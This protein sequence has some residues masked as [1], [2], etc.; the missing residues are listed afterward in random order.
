MSTRAPHTLPH[1]LEHEKAVLGAILRDH[2]A[3]V[4]NLVSDRLR[5]DHFF[6]ESHSR[7][8]IAMLELD[9]AGQ[10]TDLLTVADKLRRQAKGEDDIGPAY[11]VELMEAAP[12]A[13]NIDHYGTVV[14]DHFYLRQIVR[15]CQATALKA[16]SYD[17]SVKELVEEV[18]KEFISITN[19]HDRKGLVM[20]RDVLPRALEELESRINNDGKMTG[21][22]SGF[23]DI[24]RMT[25]GWQ[26][27]DLILIGA[28]P[29]MGK[30]AFALN[31][32][33]N[34]A[35]AGHSVAF[36]TLEMADTQLINRLLSSESQVDS[37]KFR[38]GEMDED[39]RD[40]LMLGA[41]ELNKLKFSV[42]QTPG[43]T[44][45][46]LRSRARRFKKEMGLDLIIIDYLQLMRGSVGKRYD[47]REHEISE[48]SRELKGLAKELSVPIVA[49]AQLNR[50]VEKRNDRTPQISDLRESGSIEQD[51]DIILMLYRDDYYDKNSEDA[52]IALLKV[53]KN[54]HGSTDDIQLAFKPN[55]VKFQ[56]LYKGP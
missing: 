10:P 46:E 43:I 2:E 12:L 37:S 9:A 19:A 55:F 25:G 11:L 35:K 38:R 15:A 33:L 24:D 47:S 14:I 41:R 42:D 3:S 56:N 53:A 13:S 27:S 18:E 22:T 29:G 20:I 45:L 52:G 16:M 8:Y 51:A 26:R 32:G 30:T 5:P 36:F 50:G 40:R 6:L 34:A 48:V 44:I 49:L 21:V 31:C 28:R 54:R 23:V 4:L 39:E 1:S 7:I 17:G